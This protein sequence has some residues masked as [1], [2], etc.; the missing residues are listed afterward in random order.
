MSEL[1]T[2]ADYL[3]RTGEI[4][5]RSV[6]RIKQSIMEE[7]EIRTEIRLSEIDPNPYQ[8]RVDFSQVEEMAASLR[9]HGQYYP[10]LVHRAGDRYEVADGETRYR[11]AKLNLERYDEGAPDSIGAVI[12]DYSNEDM[13]LIAF[14]T[15]YQRKDLNPIEE[16]KGIQR[17]H[18]ELGISYEDLASKLSKPQHYLFERVRLLNLPPRLIEHVHAQ[19][20]SPSQAINIA[21]V[22]KE[23]PDDEAFNKF[24]DEA[25]EDKLSVHK[26]REKKREVVAAAK[27]IGPELTAEEL[28]AAKEL[29]ELS[30]LWRV[31]NKAQRTKVLALVES[32]GIADAVEPKPKKPKQAKVVEPEPS[33]TPIS[34]KV[35]K[36]MGRRAFAAKALED[37]LETLD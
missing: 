16:A 13:A 17:L 24:V 23:L 35:V 12:K 1:R 21:T 26:I 8:P 28:A 33:K 31:M 36:L 27:A 34:D 37:A 14:R 22:R 29:K 6:A 9:D 11:A 20:L 15:A 25:V 19:S 30:K 3:A 7:A 10:I 4:R 2:N 32:F 18:D 5:S